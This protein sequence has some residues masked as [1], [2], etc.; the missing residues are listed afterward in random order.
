MGTMA[1]AV[2][3]DDSELIQLAAAGDIGAFDAL[4]RHHN[5]RLYRVARSVLHD[6]ADAEEAVQEAWWKAYNHLQDFRAEARPATWLTRIA[7]NEALMLRRRNKSREAVIQSAHQDQRTQDTMPMDELPLAIPASSQPDQQA[8]RSELRSLI[9]QRIDALPDIYR[10]VFVLRGVEG[11]PA[12]EVAAALDLPE[13]TIRVRFMR[14]RRL[15]Q[16]ALSRDIDQRTKD[17][18]S[19]A[20]ERCDRIVA[21]VHA[22]IK[23]QASSR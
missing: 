20:G 2:S 15:L 11:M 8:W 5:Q 3:I 19:F 21:A 7:I 10:S 9:E 1:D 22:R 14:A 17:A 4:M 12:S 6:E 13:A 23:H 16:D 18:F